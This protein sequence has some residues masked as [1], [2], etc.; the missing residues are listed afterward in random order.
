MAVSTNSA[1]LVKPTIRKRQFLAALDDVSKSQQALSQS[2][3][4]STI[5]SQFTAKT[6]LFSASALSPNAQDWI[7]TADAYRVVSVEI[8]ATVVANY[9]GSPDFRSLPVIHYCFEDMDTDPQVQTSWFRIRDR[10]NLSRTVLRANNPSVLVATIVPR[11]SFDANGTLSPGNLIG[12][13][14]SW[15]DSLNL[16]QIYTGLRAYSYCPATDSSGQTY[17]Y[18]I[19]YSMRYHVDTKCPI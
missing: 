14:N 19:N 5:G 13:R 9:D 8:Y 2:Q 17:T 6:L 18:T 1:A 11:P 10:S 4:P 3:T 15:L 12:L 16:S 7:Q